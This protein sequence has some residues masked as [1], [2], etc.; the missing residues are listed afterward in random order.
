MRERG[1]PHV[2]FLSA[3]APPRRKLAGELKSRVLIQVPLYLIDPE[4]QVD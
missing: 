2:F 3:Q 4:S 1:R